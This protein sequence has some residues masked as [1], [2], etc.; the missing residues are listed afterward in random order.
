[1]KIEENHRKSIDS[2]FKGR[3]KNILVF[4]C[5]EFESKNVD[6]NERKSKRAKIIEESRSILISE[7]L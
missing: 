6:L 3:M 4:L 7:V 2:H 1:M 5:D